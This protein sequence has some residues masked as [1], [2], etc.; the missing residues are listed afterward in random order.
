MSVDIDAA[1]VQELLDYD[2]STGGLRWRPRQPHLFTGREHSAEHLC[3]SWNARFAGKPACV[4]L[5][6]GGYLM[7]RV[8]WKLYL[9]HRVAWCVHHGEWPLLDIDHINHDRSDNHIVSLRCVDKVENG[10]NST[11][12]VAN[13][14]GFTGVCWHDLTGK[15]QARICVG[16]KW[17]HLGLFGNIDEAVQARQ[18]ANKEH[19]FHLNHG[20]PY[21]KG[22]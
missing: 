3:D 14:S 5:H 7:G 18:L 13:T 2:P 22:D 21:T 17:V 10:R 20:Q 8:L 12:S 4:T 11:L 15:W 1:L 9:A 16:R 6:K 19:G